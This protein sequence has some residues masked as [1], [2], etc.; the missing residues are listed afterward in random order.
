MIILH[1]INARHCAHAT[2]SVF[3]TTYDDVI[4]VHDELYNGCG[5]RIRN[6]AIIKKKTKE[7][8]LRFYTALGKPSN[9]GTLVRNHLS[10]I[11]S[12]KWKN[13]IINV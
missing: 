13:Q 6:Q 12:E 4:R 2:K 7:K 9:V 8:N 10:Q 11:S 1:R 3:Q 5:V